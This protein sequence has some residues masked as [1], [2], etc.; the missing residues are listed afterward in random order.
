M[1]SKT[2]VREFTRAHVKIEA[3]VASGN[4]IVIF[5][6]TRDISLNGLYV[7]CDERLPPGTSCRLTL[8]LGESENQL[9]I[10]ARGR[11]TRL[12]D[13]G[14]G[15]EITEIPVESLDH[16]RR[17]VLYNSGGDSKAIEQ[18]FETHVGIQRRK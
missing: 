4:A 10:R 12:D 6:Q 17:L 8:F 2:E 16:M 13:S 9:T 18:E 5:G 14:M 11:I 15:I 3:R 7:I 1:D